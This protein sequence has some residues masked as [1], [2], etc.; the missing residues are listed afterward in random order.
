MLLRFARVQQNAA[1]ERRCL[2]FRR[3]A[4]ST[5]RSS[6]VRLIAVGQGIDFT[7]SLNHDLS[8]NDKDAGR[9]LGNT[10]IPNAL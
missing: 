7:Q 1:T 10:R 3:G 9:A 5:G 4:S 2:V 8:S 6:G